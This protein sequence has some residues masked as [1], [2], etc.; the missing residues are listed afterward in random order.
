[1]ARGITKCCFFRMLS[2]ALDIHYSLT[3]PI[4]LDVQF[5]V[6]GFTALLGASG[7]GKT[8]L[9][10]ALAGLLPATGTPWEA[11][12]AQ[13]RPIGYVPQGSALFPHLNVLENVA[14]ALRGKQRLPHAQKLLD[15]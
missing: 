8:S 11:M 7:A 5:E 3:T 1:M 4:A 14:F 12:P 15:D 10:K 13:E 9:L 2:R 6:R